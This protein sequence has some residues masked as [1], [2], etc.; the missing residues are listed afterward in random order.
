M[1]ETEKKGLPPQEWIVVELNRLFEPFAAATKATDQGNPEPLAD[2]L[3]DIGIENA[4]EHASEGPIVDTVANGASAADG[5][6]EITE[7][8]FEYS[9]FTEAILA[10][11]TLIRDGVQAVK[12]IVT[13]IMAL[14]DLNPG[15][16]D[17]EALGE[18]VLD[19]LIVKY[20]RNHHS[21]VYHLGLVAG[22]IVEREDRHDEVKLDEIGRLLSNPNEI[23]AEVFGWGTEELRTMVILHYLRALFQNLD[24]TLPGTDFEMNF[25][26]RIE[27]AS[28]IGQSG[29]SKQLTVPVLEVS[30]DNSFATTGFQVIPMP[31]NGALPGLAVVPYGEVSGSKQYNLEGGWAFNV[32]ASGELDNFGLVTRP[33][34]DPEVRSLGQQDLPVELHGDARISY[35][36]TGGEFPQTTLLGDPEA[37][38]LS[39]KQASLRVTVDYTGD[40]LVFTVTLPARGSIG[41]HPKDFGGFLS[42]VMPEGGIFYDYDCVVGWSSKEGLFFERGGTLEAAIPQQSSVGPATLTET[43]L[44]AEP[45]DG[46]GTGSAEASGAGGESNAGA[47]GGNNAGTGGGNNAGASSGGNT[48][49]SASG[50]VSVEQTAGTITLVGA[51]SAKVTLGPVTATVRRV[52]VEADVSFP[53]DR[54]GNMGP[55]DME[56]GFHPPSGVGIAIEAGP[57][58]GGGYLQFDP[59]EERYAGVLQ[60]KAESLTINAVGLLTTE[61]PGGKDGFSL[62]VIISGEFPPVQLGMGFTLNGV[63]GL[64]GV[65]RSVRGK[66]LGKAVRTGSAGSLLFPEN[67]VANSQRII[68]DLRSI[69][70]PTDGVHVVG[71]MAKLGYGAGSMITFDVGVILSIPTWKIVLL[72]KIS[73]ALPSKEEAMIELNLAV[74]GVLDIPNKRVAIDA[75]LYDSRIVMFT[76]SG[77]MALRS[78]WGDDPRFVLSVGGWNP[79]FD[80]PSNF[81]KLDRVKASMSESNFRV[82][83]TGY[84]AVTSNTFQVGAGVHAVA[85]VGPLRA[86]GK[87]A[88]DALF[89]FNPFKFIIDFLA[90]FSVT[91][92]G[93]GL[94]VKIDGTFMGPGPFRL[95]GTVSI[96]ILMFSVTKN[97]D[98]TIGPSKRSEKLP[99]ARI[100]PKLTDELGKPM[101]WQAQLPEDGPQLVT[102]RDVETGDGEVLAHP[103]G[104]IGVRQTVVPL[105]YDIEKFGN[106]TPAKYTRFSISDVTVGGSSAITLD[107]PVTEEFAPAKYRKM[108][109]QEKL[110][111]PAFE[112]HTAGRSMS[113]EGIYCGYPDKQAQ[114]KNSRGA[115]FEYECTV[116]DRQQDNWA[117]PLGRLGR[118]QTAGLDAMSALPADVGTALMAVSASARSPARQAG[119]ERFRLADRDLAA[120]DAQAAGEPIEVDP[121]AVTASVTE[122]SGEGATD[123]GTAQVVRGGTNPDVGGL[124][125]SVSVGEVRYTVATADEL[126]EVDVPGV[127]GEMSKSQ[128][129]QALAAVRERRP[130]LARQLRVVEAHRV[131]GAG[132]SQA[133]HHQE[134][135]R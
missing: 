48:G 119:D 102:L 60:L 8:L 112:S 27:E 39:V 98:V 33:E 61:L 77:D 31:G 42:K 35:S 12:G 84:L 134:G 5:L 75:S 71:P 62:L 29:D 114:S 34:S 120:F 2:L 63:G 54:D 76:V 14:D 18:A 30:N 40:E 100:L 86:E 55:V 70:P 95:E 121:A 135:D 88:F 111:S 25:P 117:T 59:E 32:E 83:L 132:A 80:P 24:V 4:F 124:A 67:P 92:K 53:E 36:G 128:A 91:F 79:R 118:F 109:D 23:P 78:R 104:Q 52:G 106:A 72:G 131:R 41:V 47:S 7:A 115:T 50:S 51:A 116:I 6:L 93:K 99:R 130:A 19:T 90:Q 105:G 97:I 103:L 82:E 66:P 110:D 22:L 87:L 49:V 133:G 11:P 123:G 73:A 9:S 74:A 15:T 3:R 113:H 20:L 127:D 108:S 13:V 107:T 129:Q 122:G 68:S 16:L 43:Y 1:S 28:D 21:T 26:A 45:P 38:R 69:F 10:E 126:R 96:D 101:N 89:E 46:T 85:S 44:A 64:I 37:S 17:V 58:S 94:S 57:V 56:M 81:P 65:N 125:G